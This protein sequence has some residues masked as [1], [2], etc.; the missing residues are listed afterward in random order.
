ML[1]RDEPPADSADFLK[2]ASADVLEFVRIAIKDVLQWKDMIRVEL[3]RRRTAELDRQ[4]QHKEQHEII[5]L[6]NTSQTQSALQI[7]S[8]HAETEH[9]KQIS[10][11]SK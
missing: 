6:A 1:H 11:E 9:A 7:T 8:V 5:R 2:N 10:I 4:A 3:I